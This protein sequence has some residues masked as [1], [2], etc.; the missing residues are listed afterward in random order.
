MVRDALASLTERKHVSEAQLLRQLRVWQ[1]AA[2]AVAADGEDAATGAVADAADAAGAGAEERVL[3]ID[4]AQVGREELTAVVRACV[5]ATLA[6]TGDARVAQPWLLSSAAHEAAARA[7][8]ADPHAASE[9]LVQ[10]EELDSGSGDGGT[11]SGGFSGRAP[12]GAAPPAAALSARSSGTRAVPRR[13]AVVSERDIARAADLLLQQVGAERV[14]EEDEADHIGL[15]DALARLLAAQAR[16]VD[17]QGTVVA[18]Q[19]RVAAAERR[20]E[21]AHRELAALLAP[22]AGA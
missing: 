11:A 18:A 10:A 12:P 13:A 22:E 14:P 21:E 4:G 16:L 19:Q 6:R 9:L 7:A 8:L 5:A 15:S 3:H 20:I 2:P 1:R 17:G